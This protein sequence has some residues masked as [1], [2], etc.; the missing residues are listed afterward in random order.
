MRGTTKGK[1]APFLYIGDRQPQ[2]PLL[3]REKTW[4]RKKFDD[5]KRG[6]ARLKRD[7]QTVQ[8]RPSPCGKTV[9]HL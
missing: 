6:V 4:Q 3:Q 1:W 2:K 5:R 7:V 9:S 8:E